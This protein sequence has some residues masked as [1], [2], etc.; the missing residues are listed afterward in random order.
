MAIALGLGPGRERIVRGNER[1]TVLSAKVRKPAEPDGDPAHPLSLEALEAGRRALA[2]DP[3]DRGRLTLIVRRREDGSREILSRSRLTIA[4]GVPGDAWSLRPPS[5]PRAQ[6]AV[7]QTS[8]A[9]LIANGQPL[10]TFGDNLFVELDLSAGNLPIGTRLAVGPAVVEVTSKPHNGCSKFHARFGNDA[11]RFVQ[12]PITRH[13][14]RRGI[15]W[16]VIEEGEV[17]AGDLVQVRSRPR[18]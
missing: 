8:V 9:R 1:R 15:Y 13:Q 11:L 6:L 4:D 16:R 10:T 14:N 7:M 17:A 5:D 18:A 12:A 2:P 3:G